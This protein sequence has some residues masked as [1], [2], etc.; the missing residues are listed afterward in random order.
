MSNEATKK[1]AEEQRRQEEIK[2]R[3][4]A[5]KCLHCGGPAPHGAVLCDA[6]D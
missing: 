6:C 5:P 1:W 3:E 4:N 2:R